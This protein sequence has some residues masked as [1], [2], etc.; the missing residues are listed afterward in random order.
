MNKYLLNIFK[1]PLTIFQKKNNDQKQIKLKE[2]LTQDTLLK[3]AFGMGIVIIASTGISYVQIISRITANTLTQFELY[4]KLRAERE[5]AIFNLA[6]DNHILLKQALIDQLKKNAN[7]DTTVEFNKYFVRYNDGSIRNRP[8]LFKLDQTAGVFLGKNVNVDKEM[9]RRIVAFYTVINNYGPA[10]RNRFANTYTQIPE[11]GMV[12]YMHQYPW[13][14]KAPSRESFRVTDD[15]SFQITRKIYDPERKTTW[16][17][18]YYDQVAV[19]W[20]ASCVT[21]LDDQNG[22]HIATLGHDILIG[23]LQKRTINDKQKGTY[24]MIFREDGRLVAHP[25]LMEEIQKENG[26]F[27]IAHAKDDH[28]KQIYDLVTKN[29]QGKIIL[30]NPQYD[31]YLGIAKIEEPNW[32]LVTVFPKSLLTKEALDTARMILFLGLGALVIEIIVVFLILQREISAPLHKLMVATESIADGNLDIQV[33]V[34]R[35]NEFGRLGYLFNQMAQQVRES[36]AILAKSNEELETRV[37]ARTVELQQA[38]QLA[39]DANKSKSEFLANMSHE[40]RTPLNAIIGYSEMLQEEAEDLDQPDF[41]PDLV[42]IHSAGKHLLGL[43]NDILDLSKIEAGRMELYLESFDLQTLI[44]DVSATI[45]PLIEKN[46]NTLI[47]NCDDG[48]GNMNADLTK[49]RQSLFNLLSNASKFTENGS[50]TLTV[51]RYNENEQDWIKFQVSDSGIGMNPKQMGKLFQAFTQADASTTRK[52]GGTGLGLVITQKFCQMMGGDIRVESEVGVGSTFTID[53]PAN[54]KVEK[55]PVSENPITAEVES[56]SHQSP[57]QIRGKVLVIDDDPT[58]HD[59]VKRFLNKEGFEVIT[60]S[61]GE[62][63]I[64]LAK[65]IRPEAITLDVM[66]P[67]M[68]GW[69]VLTNL[70]KDSE[71]ADIP[72]IMMTMI[73][74]RNL[75][76]SLGAADYLLKPIDRNLLTTT[77]HKYEL[78]PNADVILIVEDEP[79]IREMTRRQLEKDNWQVLE[80]ENGIKALEILTSHQPGLILLDLMMPEMDGFEFVNELRKQPLWRE[81]PV[82]VLTAKELTQKDIAQL[83]GYVERIVQKGSY[84]RETLLEEVNSFLLEA[85]ARKNHT[86]SDS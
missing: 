63:G 81:I 80:A 76:Y 19:A 47:I 85:I 57:I 54:V 82:V 42:K 46:S 71:L 84:E 33:D 72:V 8:E 55:P 4:I 10:W 6:K 37:E 49:I 12:M 43:I 36:F 32:Y 77:L 13:S 45:H 40:L 29:Q 28:V 44:K 15:E 74:N 21:P 18:I 67:G 75:G 41:I 26:A 64:R 24:N 5:N 79:T 23:D 20:M 30:D 60:A 70:K 14:L 38:K 1:S 69:S 62:E 61:N 9:Q 56:K 65:E 39:D 83:N 86:D 52:Y 3:T 35:E 59:L 31:E 68:D 58:V 73:D 11:N 66:M 25:Q 53:L 50:I 2:S 16:T 51:N 34:K 22:K 48:I 7:T 17:G 78:E 27:S